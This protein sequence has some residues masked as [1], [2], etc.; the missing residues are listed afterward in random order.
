MLLLAI[1]FWLIYHAIPA[2]AWNASCNYPLLAEATLEEL[3]DGLENGCFTSVD[4][5]K[6]FRNLLIS[7]F[8]D[9]VLTNQDLFCPN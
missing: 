9:Y 5:V 8:G 1:L 6:V 7:I 3:N 2:F 4:L